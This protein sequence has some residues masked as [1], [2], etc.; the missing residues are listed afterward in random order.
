MSINPHCSVSAT[1]SRSA[2]APTEFHSKPTEKPSSAAIMSRS[3][4][5]G[6]PASAPQDLAQALERPDAKASAR[7]YVPGHDVGDLTLGA[8]RVDIQE[9]GEA[10]LVGG[11]DAGKLMF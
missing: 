7:M 9:L 6:L 4:P 11:L 1:K 2:T 3:M 10:A 5:K 8:V